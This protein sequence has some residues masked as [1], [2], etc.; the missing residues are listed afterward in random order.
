MPTSHRSASARDVNVPGSGVR[1][2]S[3]LGGLLTLGGALASGLQSMIGRYLDF[4]VISLVCA[5][6]DEVNSVKSC[7][8]EELVGFSLSITDAHGADLAD[9]GSSTE[10]QQSLHRLQVDVK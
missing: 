4:A 5:A 8:Q 3:L 1:S 6:P 7:V 10:P 2:W 9:P